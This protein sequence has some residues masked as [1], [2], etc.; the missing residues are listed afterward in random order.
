MRLRGVLFFTI[1]M[2]LAAGTTNASAPL[3]FEAEVWPD[4]GEK[5]GSYAKTNMSTSA[6]MAPS[7]LINEDKILGSTYYDTLSILKSSNDCSE[8]FGGSDASVEIFNRLMGQLSKGHFA[9][10]IGMRMSGEVTTVFNHRTKAQY[11]LFNKVAINSRGPFYKKRLSIS[12]PSVTR[13]GSFEPNTQEARML[14]FLHELGH[15]VKG[16]NGRWLLPNDGNDE[17]LSRI[18]TVKVEE[19]CGDE[20]KSVTRGEAGLKVDTDTTRER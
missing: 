6:S 5:N 4:F 15:L 16:P 3:G 14:I 20:I 11:R 13:I 8:F 19:V 1:L 2:S 7:P 17:H 12:E 18:N 10:P 9:A